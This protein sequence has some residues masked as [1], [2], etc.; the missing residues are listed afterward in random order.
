MFP[1]S[2]ILRNGMAVR[3][4]QSLQV[5]DYPVQFLQQLVDFRRTHLLANEKKELCFSADMRHLTFHNI[6]ME[7][8]VVPGKIWLEADESSHLS[9]DR[10]GDY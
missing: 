5:I 7:Q 6:S 9:A 10:S 1:E 4:H 3:L 8:V 2:A